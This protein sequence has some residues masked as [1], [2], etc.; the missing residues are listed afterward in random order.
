MKKIDYDENLD[1]II[2]VLN[3]TVFRLIKKIIIS[4][5]IVVFTL[6]SLMTPILLPN[7]Q[8]FSKDWIFYTFIYFI[9]GVPMTSR[10]A[11]NTEENKFDKIS[12]NAHEKLDDLVEELKK[13]N[14]DIKEENLVN[15]NKEIIMTNEEKIIKYFY[16]LDKEN[17]IQVLKQISKNQLFLYEKEDIK[18][19][20]VIQKIKTIK[21]DMK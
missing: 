3:G 10:M 15:A 12:K 18:D 14:I 1:D 5:S 8:F 21:K 13:E 17:Q 20:D 6:A 4:M 16:L 7:C 9:I 19:I 11:I 2:E